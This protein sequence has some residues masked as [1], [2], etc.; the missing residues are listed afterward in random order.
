MLFV[1]LLQEGTDIANYADDTTPYSSAET[2]ECVI[3]KLK[4]S[5]SFLFKWISNNSRKV[6]SGKRHLAMSGKQGVIA[7]IDNHE[8]ES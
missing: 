6:N 5:S 3:E 2:Q 8:F 7:K 1:L 4:G